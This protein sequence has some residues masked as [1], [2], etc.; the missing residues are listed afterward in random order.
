MGR[1]K[2]RQIF[3]KIKRKN[4]LLDLFLIHLFVIFQNLLLINKFS[5]QN[6][7]LLKYLSIFSSF[8][9]ENLLLF[10]H[11]YSFFQI[12][13]WFYHHVLMTAL[14]HFSKLKR[15]VLLWNPRLLFV[16]I[17]Q[18]VARLLQLRQIRNTML[19]R[20]LSKR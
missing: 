18:P 8:R 19:K 6:N 3:N 20:R 10:Q 13:Q 5:F 17:I 1:K 15:K 7:R 11:D 12:V 2:G 9:I 16:L 4:K 14:F